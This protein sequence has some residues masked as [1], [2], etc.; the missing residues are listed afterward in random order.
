[1]LSAFAARQAAKAAPENDAGPS[2]RA[3]SKPE[4]PQKAKRAS[5]PQENAIKPPSSTSVPP[6]SI[7]RSSS[8]AAENATPRKRKRGTRLSAGA[9]GSLADAFGQQDDM[10]I[11]PPDSDSDDDLENSD[12]VDVSMEEPVAVP[13]AWSPSAPAFEDSLSAP[14]VQTPEVLSTYEPIP[15]QNIFLVDP[16][17]LSIGAQVSSAASSALTLLDEGAKACFVG[18]YHLTVVKGAVSIAGTRLGVSALSHRIYAPTS[19]PLPVIDALADDSPSLP[20]P[21]RL[22]GIVTGAACVILIQSMTTGIEGLPRVCQRFEGVFTPRGPSRL[23]PGFLNLRLVRCSIHFPRRDMEVFSL[24]PTWSSA[25]DE[26]MTA[27]NPLTLIKGPK[28]CGKSTAA[29]TMLNRLLTKHRRVAVLECDL[30]QSEFT[31]AGMVAL[32]VISRPVFGPPFTHPTLPYRSHYIGETTPKS[33]P[34]HYLAAIEALLETYRLDLQTPALD[35]EDEEEDED[36][37]I[38]D[39]IPLVVNTMGWTK[40]LGADLLRR[41]E[42]IIQPTHILEFETPTLETDWPRTAFT[43]ADYRTISILSYFHAEFPEADGSTESMLK[44]LTAETWNTARPLVAQLPYEVDCARAIDAVALLGAGADEVVASEVPRVLNGALVGLVACE[45]EFLDIDV[46]AG[47]DIPY[48]QGA[49][50][51]PPASSH[52]LGLALVRGVSAGPPWVLQVLTPVPPARLGAARVLVKGGMELPI[53]GMLDWMD[54]ERVAGVERDKVPYLQ[55][56]KGDGI[57]AERRRVRRN[58]MRKA[59]A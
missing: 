47:A 39:R 20:I 15:D 1:M 33:S 30:G 38:A 21:S 9:A 5:K 40:G 26:V 58:L 8:S 2:K 28:K 18:N 31:P 22:Q 57:G 49:A 6:R 29:R 59:L 50:P 55:W 53:W 16:E 46:D 12:A 23:V 51:P 35:D 43:A 45:P 42:D 25:M 13:R 56:G 52:C 3:S 27:D 41:V 44:Q 54:E 4:N 14:T 48:S 17:E 36:E 34:S 32:N 11:V 37:R 7:K 10:I 19:S 24:P